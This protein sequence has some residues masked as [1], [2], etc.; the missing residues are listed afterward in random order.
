MRV[1]RCMETLQT[2]LKFFGKLGEKSK[3]NASIINWLLI[4]ER[5]TKKE[6]WH[7]MPFCPISL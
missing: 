5:D 2:S 1:G 4:R 6:E 7:S 3:K